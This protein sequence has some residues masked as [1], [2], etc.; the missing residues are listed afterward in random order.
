V[1]ATAARARRPAF[2]QA[3]VPDVSVATLEFDGGALGSVSSTCL[4]G[5]KHR[6]GI[7]LFCEG[8]ALELS[9]L[10]LVVDVGGGPAVQP[11][12]VDAKTLA[13]RRFVD[14]VQGRADGVRATYEAVLPTHRLACALA[15]SA[16]E[17]RCLRATDGGAYA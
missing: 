16:E 5:W 8:M 1:H 4:L 3:D 13:D 9:E 7:H 15:R 17:R 11:A 12:E 6:A 2:P 10:E 14:A